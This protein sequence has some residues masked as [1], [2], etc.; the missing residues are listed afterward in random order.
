MIEIKNIR[1]DLFLRTGGGMFIWMGWDT[2]RTSLQSCLKVMKSFKM[3]LGGGWW[4]N[5][6]LLVMLENGIFSLTGLFVS[7]PVASNKQPFVDRE[8]QLFHQYRRDT[9]CRQLPLRPF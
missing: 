6:R 8:V 7:S 2:K 3:S 4:G 1:N 5:G 9:N